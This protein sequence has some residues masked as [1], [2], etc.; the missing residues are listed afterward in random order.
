MCIACIHPSHIS[1][2]IPWFTGYATVLSV[3]VEKDVGFLDYSI[4]FSQPALQ[5]QFT[6][7][8]V[9]LTTH[10]CEMWPYCQR[11]LKKTTFA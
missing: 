4:S 10:H 9:Q 11:F 6:N 3:R 2:N 8:R 1:Q 5:V 7:V